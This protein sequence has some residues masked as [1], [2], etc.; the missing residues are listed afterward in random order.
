MAYGKSKVMRMDKELTKRAGFQ[1]HRS[2]VSNCIHPGT[3]HRCSYLFGKDKGIRRLTIYERAQGFCEGC[4]IKHF[5][6]WDDGEWHHV[7]GGL[8]KQHCDCVENGL[9]VCPNFHRK[10]HVAVRS[11]RHGPQKEAAG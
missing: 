3:A 8:G 2:Y 4:L 9:W 1:D 5:I 6:G 11:A 7:K 10:Q